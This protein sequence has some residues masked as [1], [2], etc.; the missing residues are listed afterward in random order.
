MLQILFLTRAIRFLP[1][2]MFG[3]NK[4]EALKITRKQYQLSKTE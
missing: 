1:T 2:K 4:T 3:G